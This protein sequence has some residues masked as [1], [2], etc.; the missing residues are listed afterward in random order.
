MSYA[1]VADMVKRYQRR[2][3]DLLTKTRTDNGQPDDSI[4]DA[5]LTDATAL[6]D[7]YIVARYTLPL[8]VVPATLPQVCGV[9]AWYYLNDVR[10][11]EQATQRYK[12][13]I[14]W[15]EGVRDG[16]IPLGTDAAGASPDGENLV[17]VSSDPVVFS[18]NQQG[19]I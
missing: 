8:T 5:A 16:K 6:M 9:I 7:S 19:F 4:I 1:T 13:A 10:A 12:D 2:N 18:R 15:L 14:R 17:E 11:T 3:L